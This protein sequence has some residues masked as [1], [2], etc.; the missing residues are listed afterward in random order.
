MEIFQI[1]YIWRRK[2]KQFSAQIEVHTFDN[3]LLAIL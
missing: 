3:E 1:L 2:K